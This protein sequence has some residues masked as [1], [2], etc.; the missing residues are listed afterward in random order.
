MNG[1]D[2]GYAGLRPAQIRFE[3]NWGRIV[4]LLWLAIVLAVAGAI[5]IF[6][7]R[8]SLWSDELASVFFAQQ[9]LGNLW[10]GW[11]VRETNPPLYYSLLQGW[12]AAVGL[13]TLKLR[14]FSILAGLLAIVVTYVGIGQNYTRRAGMIAALMLALSAQQL[15]FSLM[16]RSYI[17]LYLAVS[18]SFFG[19]LAIVRSLD[20]HDHHSFAGW[21]AYVG[22]AIAGVYLHTTAC[23]WPIAASISLI[24]VDR[25]FRPFGGKRWLDLFYADVLIVAGASWWLYIT[26]IQLQGPNGNISWIVWPGMRESASYIFSTVFLSRDTT[27]WAKIIPMAI[28]GFALLAAI[29]TI[30]LPTTRIALACPIAAVL[31][32]ILL[33]LKQPVIMDK[34]ILWVSV[35]PLTLAA[36]GLDSI[37]NRWL[38]GTATAVTVLLLGANL[39]KNSQGLRIENWTDAVRTIS[40]NPRAVLVVDGES[41]GVSANVSCAID[42]GSS[43]CPFPIITIQRSDDV[44]D[45]WAFGYA[46]KADASPDGRLALPRDANIYLIRRK[47]HDVLAAL[48]RVDLL[49][50]IDTTQPNVLGPYGPPFAE[51]LVARIPLRSGLL[52]VAP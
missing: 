44:L 46:A 30:K 5:R 24:A 2:E 50:S 40:R 39:A 1:L 35:F 33:S 14:L 20:K 25:R 23:I 7:S 51:N 16:V 48:H 8:Y 45:P 6:S 41:M 15:N 11:M 52:R 28:A 29:R 31:L 18:I 36:V 26:Y 21:A 3:S 47:S 34:T 37:R 13:S 38:F 22:G 27:G 32:F 42:L 43:R 10:S 19:L 12:I 4:W 9:P 49:R 17:F